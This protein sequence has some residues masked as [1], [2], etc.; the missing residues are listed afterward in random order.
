M[1]R[2]PGG[3]GTQEALEMLEKSKMIGSP[4]GIG[5]STSQCRRSHVVRNAAGKEL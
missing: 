3:N 1:N 2:S 4:E 5:A